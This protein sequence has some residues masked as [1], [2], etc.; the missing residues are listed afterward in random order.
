MLQDYWID[1]YYVEKTHRSDGTGGIEDVYTIGQKFRG[2]AVKSSSQEQIVA[3]V[4]G[5]VG[6]RYEVTTNKNNSLTKDDIIMFYDANDRQVFLKISENA[7]HTPNHSNQHEWKYM[8][9]NEFK[10]DLRVVN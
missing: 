6:E 2:G 1:L 5:E 8:T 9:A 4:R 7:N 3:S 10:P